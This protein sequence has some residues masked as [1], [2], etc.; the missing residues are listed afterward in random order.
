[1]RSFTI[2]T[3]SPNIVRVSNLWKMRWVGHI[4]RMEAMRN[5]CRILVGIS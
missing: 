4:A 5:A 3:F 1:M 2:Y